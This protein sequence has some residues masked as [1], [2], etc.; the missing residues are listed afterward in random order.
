VAALPNT[1]TI[2]V[3]SITTDTLLQCLLVGMSLIQ[4]IKLWDRLKCPEE[5]SPEWD[6][7]LKN[8]LQSL[9]KKRDHS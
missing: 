4:T 7:G 8:N 1:D 5:Q 2:L 9:Q 3:T 6:S